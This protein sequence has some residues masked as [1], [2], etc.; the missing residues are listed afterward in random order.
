M[1]LTYHYVSPAHLAYHV[2]KVAVKH[3]SLSIIMKHLDRYYMSDIYMLAPI[4]QIIQGF[5]GKQQLSQ[6]VNML[7]LL[8]MEL[9]I[10]VIFLLTNSNYLLVMEYYEVPH[11]SISPSLRY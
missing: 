6:D 1:S 8:Q 9:I 10:I 5:C 2:N 7:P 11:R 3:Q 4:H